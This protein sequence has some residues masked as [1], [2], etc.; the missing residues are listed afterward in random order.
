ML[1]LKPCFHQRYSKDVIS[2]I[3]FRRNICVSSKI[4]IVIEKQYFVKRVRLLF[5]KAKFWNFCTYRTK[6]F[7]FLKFSIISLILQFNWSSFFPKHIRRFE[8]SIKPFTKNLILLSS[9]KYNYNT[10]EMNSHDK[11]RIWS[12]LIF[13]HFQ[14]YSFLILQKNKILEYFKS[15]NFRKNFINSSYFLNIGPN[16]K[17]KNDKQNSKQFHKSEIFFFFKLLKFNPKIISD[18]FLFLTTNDLLFFQFL[19]F[20][21]FFYTQLSLF[22]FKGNL[23]NTRMRLKE[24]FVSGN[25]VLTEELVFIEIF[26][27]NIFYSKK[28]NL[29]EIRKLKNPHA[30]KFNAKLPLSFPIRIW[31]KNLNNQKVGIFFQKVIFFQGNLSS[32][33]RF[34]D[35]TETIPDLPNDLAF[36]QN[37]ES[38]VKMN[39]K[40]NLFLTH[41]FNKL[42]FG[43]RHHN[44]FEKF[45][46]TAA[47]SENIFFSCL[48]LENFPLK[49][50]EYFHFKSLQYNKDF[51]SDCYHILFACQKI[52]DR[53]LFF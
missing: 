1:K 5:Y 34:I 30:N 2:K 29:F 21:P 12:W 41:V 37:K 28:I 45:E 52:H 24:L 48:I 8:V 32:F 6:Y 39:W 14:I 17:K 35:K 3:F 46:A 47:F 22:F 15:Y 11:E 10:I 25:R 43:H 51:L 27:Q 7:N 33:S 53:L 50:I 23:L 16:I 4:E 44:K 26:L 49:W 18:I 20:S 13:S 31:K 40:N 38:Y 9:K 19:I 36:F 42:W